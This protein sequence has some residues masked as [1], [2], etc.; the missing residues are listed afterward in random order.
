[1]EY[2]THEKLLSSQVTLER[3][4][5][6]SGK[7]Q[8]GWEGLSSEERA[9]GLGWKESVQV[10]LVGVGWGGRHH[11]PILSPACRLAGGLVA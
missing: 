3:S 10:R 5:Y 1:M 11:S 6:H 2:V 9:G 8:S 4:W 7:G